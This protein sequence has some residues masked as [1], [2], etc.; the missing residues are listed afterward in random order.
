VSSVSVSKRCDDEVRHTGDLSYLLTHMRLILFREGVLYAYIIIASIPGVVT[1]STSPQPGLSSVTDMTRSE[2]HEWRASTFS[3]ERWSALQTATSISL[4]C[5]PEDLG[6]LHK[7]EAQIGSPQPRK[8]RQRTTG[9]RANRA[10]LEVL[11]RTYRDFICEEVAPEIAAV[12][13][14][15]SVDGARCTGVAFQA[16]PALRVVTPSINAAGRRHRDSDYGHQPAQINYWLPLSRACGSNTLH[17]EGLKKNDMT[18]GTPLDGDFGAMH[19]FHGNDLFHFTLPNYY[20]WADCSDDGVWT[21]RQD[22]TG[23]LRGNQAK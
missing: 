14:S 19:R 9:K 5:K 12:F 23:V 18:V 8:S 13:E 11:G 3:T 22:G 21:V 16:M 7:I 20:A 6:I 15:T 4:R 2:L 10:A 17:V 1:L